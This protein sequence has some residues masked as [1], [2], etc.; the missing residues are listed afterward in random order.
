LRHAISTTDAMEH[1]MQARGGV[2]KNL[3]MTCLT[4]VIGV[5]SMKQQSEFA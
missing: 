2:T 1:A 3:K 5:A 4:H